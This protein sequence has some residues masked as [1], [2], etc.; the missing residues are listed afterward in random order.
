MRSGRFHLA[1]DFLAVYLFSSETASK[2]LRCKGLSCIQHGSQSSWFWTKP[3]WRSINHT[4]I[5][6]RSSK[7]AQNA[8]TFCNCYPTETDR[9][10]LDGSLA[11]LRRWDSES[12][13]TVT[14]SMESL[15]ERNNKCLHST[16]KFATHGGIRWLVYWRNH[17]FLT[18][19]LAQVMRTVLTD[20]CKESCTGLPSARLVASCLHVYLVTKSPISSDSPHSFLSRRTHRVTGGVDRMTDTDHSFLLGFLRMSCYFNQEPGWTR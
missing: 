6:L 15:Y 5:A 12:F 9:T 20:S 4:E 14:S 8:W 2:S 1:L 16:H 3:C 17:L 10:V 7:P 11:R 13:C 18:L 19:S